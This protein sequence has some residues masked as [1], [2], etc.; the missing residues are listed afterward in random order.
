MTKK[1]DRFV[2]D[3]D[4]PEWTAGDFALAKPFSEVFPDHGALSMRQALE[5][6]ELVRPV[7]LVCFFT[8]NDRHSIYGGS[9]RSGDYDSS[10]VP[11]P[12]YWKN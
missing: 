2:T 5:T 11:S 8:E 4:N 3:E 12:N 1:P 6:R 7:G 10:V 9:L